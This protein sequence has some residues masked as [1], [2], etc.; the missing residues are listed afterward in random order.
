MALRL[1]I[2]RSFWTRPFGRAL[3]LVALVLVLAGTTTALYIWLY[4][5]SIID[6]RLSGSVFESR[7]AIFAAPELVSVGEA[8]D[9]QE[10]VAQLRRFGYSNPD[11]AE[12]DYGRFKLTGNGIEIHPGPSSRVQAENAA[13]IE[14][15]SGKVSRIVSL[16]GRT[17]RNSVWVDPALVTNLFDSRRTKRRLVLYEEIPPNLINA[18]LA[19]ED[20]RFFDH[21]GIS[22]IDAARALWFDLGIWVRGRKDVRPQGASTLTMQLARSFFL[23]RELSYK[24]KASEIVIALQL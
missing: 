10:L 2:A 14:F 8:R 16:S 1:R 11:Q 24:R 17:P 6:Q 19:A 21:P 7:S 13:R 3:A 12:S 15:S 9:R 23:T 5:G 22:S 4:F 18:V 20:R